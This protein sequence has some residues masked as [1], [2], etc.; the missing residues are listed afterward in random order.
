MKPPVLFSVLL[1]A[2][3]STGYISGAV[4][5]YISAS[6]VVQ[7]EME[8]QKYAQDLQ[9]PVDPCEEAPGKCIPDLVDRVM[10]SVVSIDILAKNGITQ[11]PFGDKTNNTSTREQVAGGSGFFVSS[12]GLVVTNRHVIAGKDYEYEIVTSDGRTYPAQVLAID[13]VLDLAVLKVEGGGFPALELGDSDEARPGQS[14]IAIGNTLAEFQNSVTMGIISGLNRRLWAG[15][16]DEVSAEILEEAIQT[17]TPINPGN[18]GGPLIGLDGL[19]IGV[20][21][22]VGEAQSLG[23]ALPSNAVRRVVDSVK[24]FGRIVRPWIGIRYDME[25]NGAR[26]SKSTVEQPSI[27][28]GSPADKAGLKD[29]DLITTFEHE[30]VDIDHPIGGRLANYNPGDSVV[31]AVKRGDQVIEIQLMLGDQENN[32]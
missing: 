30:A 25:A 22:A 15:G 16:T 21:T 14:V 26:I 19:V 23:F 29:G 2:T 28:P 24:Q 20:N 27:T 31:L 10:P 18:S 9:A 6:Q 8:T 3:M 32:K 13:T 4:G 17:D 7:R 12:D 1:V 11:D 5:G